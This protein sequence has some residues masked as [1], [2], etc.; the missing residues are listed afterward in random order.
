MATSDVVTALLPFLTDATDVVSL[1]NG[2]NE[3]TIAGLVG[4][5]R[6]IGCVVGFGATW[7]E[8]GHITLDADGDLQVGR[9]DGS[10]DVRLS[11][12]ADLLGL[13]FVTR[14]TS[15]IRGAL[16]GKMLV[17]S[18]T[19]LGA[20][21]GMLT[22]ELL[23][24]PAR[25]RVVC[26]VIAE[27]VRVAHAE[28]VDLPP[29]LG[30]V[31]ASEVGSDSW[32]EQM[33]AALERFGSRF[34]AIRSVTWR[35]IEIG[36]PTEIDA[37]TGTIVARGQ[38]RGVPTPLSAEVYAT[39]RSIEAGRLYPHATHLLRLSAVGSGAEAVG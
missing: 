6:T 34:G 28:G 36:R 11:A 18:M 21:A 25:R 27:G 38:A 20:L 7:I 3:D 2:I 17:N 12:V 26:S 16:W 14:T 8:P 29:I 4:A 30:R 10:S 33:D 37:V 5:E 35:D 23:E 1:Q 39:L 15:N 32:V 19:V 22:G 31:E 24:D 13:A 9:L